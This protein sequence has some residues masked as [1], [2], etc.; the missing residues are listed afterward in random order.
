M[1]PTIDIVRHAQALHNIQGSHIKDPELT[2]Q[3]LL[4]CQQ[5][6]N[7]YQFGDKVTHILSSPLKRAITTALVGIIP[8][9]DPRIK[10]QLLPALQEINGSP[11]STG[12]PKSELATHYAGDQNR[13]DMSLL[14]EDWY[15][16]GSGT[17]YAPTVSSV[18]ERARAARVFL[19]RLARRAME[20]GDDDAHI[21]VV[22]HGEFAHWLTGDFRGVMVAR[23]TNWGNAEVRSYRLK[24]INADMPD[25]PQLVETTKSISTRGL[26][27]AHISVSAGDLQII[28]RIA[29][30]RVMAYNEQLSIQEA[31][32]KTSPSNNSPEGS[33]GSDSFEKIQHSDGSDEWVDVE[34]ECDF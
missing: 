21:V 16:K 20:A 4:E 6:R 10:V 2:S 12:L 15:R 24:G 5:L 1:A 19:W 11:S 27:A 26:P 7:Q 30:G 8:A 34:D 13:V 3:G 33:D 18:Y 23:N 31:A 22:T 17:L 28:R 32:A 9:V 29:E 25:D 14:T